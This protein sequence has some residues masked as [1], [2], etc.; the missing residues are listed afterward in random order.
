MDEG[1]K[2]RWILITPNRQYFLF[3]A[4]QV[5]NIVFWINIDVFRDHEALLILCIRCNWDPNRKKWEGPSQKAERRWSP[6]SPV[7]FEGSPR[8]A[9]ACLLLHTLASLGNPLAP[10]LTLLLPFIYRIVIG[11][12]FNINLYHP[13]KGEMVIDIILPEKR[14]KI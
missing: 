12:L 3:S 1:G 10:F 9:V 4:D 8:V 7:S 14:F 13:K 11:N 6:C 5:I 2:S